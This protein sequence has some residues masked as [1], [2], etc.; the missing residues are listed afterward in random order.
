MSKAWKWLK[1][2]WYIP[3]FV[4]VSMIIWALFRRKDPPFAQTVAEIR[5]IQAEAET[6]KLRQIVGTTKA[7]ELIEEK[8]EKDIQA[9][10]EKQKKQ[11]VELRNDPAKLAKFLVRA[12]GGRAN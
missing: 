12:S 2:Y 7:K 6:E 1:K 8:Y 3:A 10:D 4:V 11:A 5:A 9:L